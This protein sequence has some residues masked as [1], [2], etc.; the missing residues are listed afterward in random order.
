[1]RKFAV[2]AC[3]LAMINSF[4]SAMS[5]TNLAYE[6]IGEFNFFFGAVAA[7]IWMVCAVRIAYRGAP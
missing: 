1:V 3:F 7:L 5:K 2:L 4:N 6:M